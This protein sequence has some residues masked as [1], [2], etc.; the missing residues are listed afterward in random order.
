MLHNTLTV[1]EL[2]H[3]WE[4]MCISTEGLQNNVLLLYMTRKLFFWW[5]K[6]KRCWSSCTFPYKGSK[7]SSGYY[8]FKEVCMGG[9]NFCYF[10]LIRQTQDFYLLDHWFLGHRLSFPPLCQHATFI[11]CAK[12]V[13][14]DTGK[15][16]CWHK[17]GGGGER[18]A[19]KLFLISLCFII[20]NTASAQN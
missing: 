4:G 13:N 5:T 6:T 15:S 17:G 18:Y 10:F 7:N 16:F 14:T 20:K 2:A 8:H 19:I 9:L 11:Y 3:L 1:A 12:Y